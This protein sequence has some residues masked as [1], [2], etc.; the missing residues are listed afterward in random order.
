MSAALQSAERVGR[1]LRGYRYFFVDEKELQSAIGLALTEAGVAFEREVRL[2][3]GDVVDFL[4]EPGIAVEVKVA[5]APA[6]IARQ[7]SRYAASPRVASLLLVSRKARHAH[8]FPA[9]L[10]G[11]PLGVVTLEASAL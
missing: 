10:G 11:K 8:R 3:P 2:S 1:V 7:L 9:T 5:G 4:V 6:E